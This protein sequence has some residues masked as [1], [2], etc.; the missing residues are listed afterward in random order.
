MKTYNKCIN[1]MAPIR[2]CDI[3]GW[4][5]T[6]FAENGAVLNFAVYPQVEV[7]ISI[8]QTDTEGAVTINAE[9]YGDEYVYN[10]KNLSYINNSE[11]EY[12]KHP[13]I[14][15]AIDSMNII[16]NK[17]L[18]YKISIYSAAPP[19]A[20]T[21]SCSQFG[22]ASNSSSVVKDMMLEPDI[23]ISHWLSSSTHLPHTVISPSFSSTVISV[24]IPGVVL[25]S[26]ELGEI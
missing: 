5:D 4:T 15:A 6:W 10:R 3:G 2:I 23:I 17:N 11:I 1:A 26:V 8:Q 24:I 20:S 21:V 13:L 16:E 18:N 19:G 25:G 9:N 14:E 22:S 12:I 7:Q